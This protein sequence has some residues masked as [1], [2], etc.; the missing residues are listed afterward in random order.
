MLELIQFIYRLNASAFGEAFHRIVEELVE[1][2]AENS[3]AVLL[4]PSYQCCRPSPF[5][6]SAVLS[7]R[8]TISIVPVTNR[9]TP[10]P[11]LRATFAGL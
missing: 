5:R 10:A 2:G 8:T 11:M 4:T 9:T 6:P 1:H 7:G 3:I